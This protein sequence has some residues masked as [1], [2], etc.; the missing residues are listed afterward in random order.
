[1]GSRWP[2]RIA[3]IAAATALVAAAATGVLLAVAP[4]PG[5]ASPE[6][7]LVGAHL[8]DADG[9]GRLAPGE[10]AHVALTVRNPGSIATTERVL[11]V[12]ASGLE[13]LE[14]EVAALPVA[15]GLARQTDRS[16][17]VRRPLDGSPTAW[18]D[19]T[20]GEVRLGTLLLPTT[21]G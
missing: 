2:A 9:D 11:L 18:L 17:I 16:I 6:L 7:Q 19:V 1:M 4:A 10:T 3:T 13:V 12:E 8:A 14:A 21:D 5:A 15:A 20:D